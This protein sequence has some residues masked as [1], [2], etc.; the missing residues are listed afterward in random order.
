MLLGERVRTHDLRIC[1]GRFR[2]GLT[3]RD[4]LRTLIIAVLQMFLDSVLTLDVGSSS[5]RAL[6]FGADGRA[7]EGVGSQIPYQAHTSEDGGWEVD[8]RELTRIVAECLTAVCG[9]LRSKG[10]RPAAVAVDTFWHSLLGVDAGGK[11]VTP[12]LHPFDSRSSAQALALAKRVDNLGQHVRTGCM[13]HPSYPP[14]KLLWM[15]ETRADAFA[16][17]TRWMSV[18]EWLFLEFFGTARA[19][20][21][22]LSA[23]GLWDQNRGDFDPEMLAALPVRRDQFAS[24]DGLDEPCSGLQGEYAGLWPE[25][26]GIPWF[27]ALGDGA[28][29]SIGSGCTTRDK[30]ALMVGT[31]GAMRVTIE[32]QGEAPQV[33]IPPGLF[34]YRVDRKRFVVGGALSNGGSVY[35]WMKRTLRLPEDDEIERQL[36]AMTPGLHGITM[37]PLF[38]GERSTGWRMDVRGAIAGLVSATTPMEILHAGLESVALR[39]RGVY[40]ILERAFG[41]PVSVVG[42]GAA[43][44]HSLVWARMMADTLGHSVLMCQER[45][46]TARGAALLALERLGV[47]G[48]VSDVATQFGDAIQPDAAKKALYLEALAK[49]RRLYKHLFGE[50]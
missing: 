19:S 7:V 27:P 6:L 40:E 43:L 21:S 14:S 44:L 48:N 2:F 8:A 49:Q 20:T 12:V 3:V 32:P 39:F 22:M 10:I 35:A 34:C 50:N 25:L 42:S 28:C 46:A 1:Y 45:E 47:I 26:G 4:A 31:S 15:A 30:W 9:Q 41:A 16:A 38:A 36:A 11:A 23:C 5:A 18:G 37:L 24:T 29:D 17:A 33:E 13:L